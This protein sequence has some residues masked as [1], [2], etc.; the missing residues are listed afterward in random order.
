MSAAP[1]YV[2]PIVGWRTW[3]VVCEGE[4]FGCG[5]SS[6]TRSGF[7]A[8]LVAGCLRRA[9]SLPWRRTPHTQHS[10]TESLA[11]SRHCMPDTPNA[12]NTQ[13]R[14]PQLASSKPIP[15]RTARPHMRILQ[16][17]Q[18]K[19]LFC[20]VFIAPVSKPE[21]FQIFFTGKMGV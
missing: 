11:Q 6:T 10:H 2:E 20:S 3:L 18:L 5:A 12:D 4:G 19:H 7:R 14:T 13:R 21:N 8:G 15:A 17:H 9:L 1:D 16:P